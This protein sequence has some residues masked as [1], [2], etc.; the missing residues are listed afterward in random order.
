MTPEDWIGRPIADTSGEPYGTLDELFV[1]RTTGEPEFGVVTVGGPA[2]APSR[3]V[4]VPLGGGRLEGD[5]VVLPLDPGRVREAPEVQRT[6][7]SIPPAVGERITAFFA[8]PGEPTT[9]MPA[10][11]TPRAETV[12]DSDVTEV[13]VSEEELVVDKRS[14]VTERVRLHKRIVEEEVSVTVTLRREELV[15]ERLP[16]D[17]ADVPPERGNGDEQLTEGVLEFVLLAEEPVVEK[18]VVPVE[19]IKVARDTIVEQ[20]RITDQVRKERAELDGD[21]SREE[22]DPL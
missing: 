11:Q 10:T 5:V 19:R 22:H 20:R 15:I 21:P 6:V 17:R 12:V 1:G 3:R 4:A 14:E 13:T 16:V 18:R 9:P 2:G 7:E 8:G